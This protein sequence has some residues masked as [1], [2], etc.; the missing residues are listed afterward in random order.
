MNA[1][2][3]AARGT[4]ND[5]LEPVDILDVT[6]PDGARI[7]VRRMST[8]ATRR[9]V[10]SHGNGLAIG[11]YAEF[12]KHLLGDAEV[13]MF[14]FRNHGMNP[15]APPSR[16]GNWP[17]FIDDFDAVLAAV[18]QRFGPK[19]SYGIFHSL[20]SLTALI[21]ASQRPHP[22]HGLV[23]FEPPAV[24]P[25]GTPER[26]EH[27]ELHRD[28][29]SRTRARRR[30]V[31][32]PAELAASFSRLLMFQR[33]PDSA[34]LEL[35]A[36]TLRKMPDA[37]GYELSC[38]PEFEADT[39][40]IWQVERHWSDLAATGCP[41]RVVGSAPETSDT[42]ILSRIARLLAHDLGFDF[43]EVRDAGHLLQLDHAEHCVQLVRD[44][45]RA[46]EGGS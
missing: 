42:A 32:S 46:A 33:M 14:D 15:P 41:V 7:L 35:A 40:E 27:Y 30:I 19:P 36:S 21:H 44:F 39:F 3:A 29:S 17:T 1:K 43:C 16:D 13:V 2:A 31:G 45:V 18:E 34:R 10:L 12:W 38:P 37:D 23:L 25:A 11:G 9:Y 22:W 8:H 5:T 4:G 20:S 6:R 26:E 24:P 28:L